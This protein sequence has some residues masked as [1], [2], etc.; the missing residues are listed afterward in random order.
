MG[1]LDARSWRFGRQPLAC[2]AVNRPLKQASNLNEAHR[3]RRRGQHDDPVPVP[4]RRYQNDNRCAI[5]SRLDCAGYE[6]A[7]G[8]DISPGI[9]AW[10][11]LDLKR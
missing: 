7:A 5:R 1:A 3:L 11:S 6:K 9:R 10:F 8:Q 2:T 4:I